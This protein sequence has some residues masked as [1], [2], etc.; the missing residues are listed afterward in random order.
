MTT[1]PEPKYKLEFDEKIAQIMVY[2]DSGLYWGTVIVKELIRVSTWLRTSSAPDTVPLLDAAWLP[3]GGSGGKPLRFPDLHLPTAHVLAYH[4]IPPARDPV[5]YDPT[6][7]NR[8]MAPVTV[9][10]GTFRFEGS[11]RMSTITDLTRYL[12]VNRELFTAL[13]E[14]EITNPVYPN[15]GKIRAPFA[16][17][18]QSTSVFANRIT[19]PPIG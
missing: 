16:L 9:L 19:N 2:M 12:T 18:R 6:E 8:I 5:D 11:L 13:H 7:K 3:L 4:L 1:D 15:V 14:V 10:A 17:V